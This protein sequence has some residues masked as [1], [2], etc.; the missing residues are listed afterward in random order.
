MYGIFTISMINV[1]NHNDLQFMRLHSGINNN[2]F[3]ITMI[4]SL[5][6]CLQLICVCYTWARTDFSV[7][8][9]ICNKYGHV[10]LINQF[11]EG[12]LT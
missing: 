7:L 2:L 3:L 8:I 12:L 5:K 6:M 11:K 1:I 9:I 4:V 10:G